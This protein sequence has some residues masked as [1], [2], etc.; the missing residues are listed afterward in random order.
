MRENE[1]DKFSGLDRQ[2][3]KPSFL[4]VV[5]V[6]LLLFLVCSLGY[7]NILKPY[8]ASKKQKTEKQI[9]TSPQEP[10][11]VAVSEPEVIVS[12]ETDAKAEETDAVAEEIIEIIAQKFGS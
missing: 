5:L 8:L 11:E 2:K 7:D 9:V 1:F 3:R 4:T 10:E 12:D 6:A